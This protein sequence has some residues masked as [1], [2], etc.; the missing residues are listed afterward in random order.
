MVVARYVR[1]VRYVWYV[2][3]TCSGDAAAHIMQ[4]SVEKGCVRGSMPTLYCAVW[5]S[6]MRL[7]SHERRHLP[8]GAGA[9][10]SKGARL[11]AR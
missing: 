10:G 11:N 5:Q 2:W 3:H 7:W 9:C 4:S 6:H 1:Y 8:S